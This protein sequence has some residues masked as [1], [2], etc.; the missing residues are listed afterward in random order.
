MGPRVFT[1]REVNALL[2]DLAR[3]FDAL[4]RVPDRLKTAKGKLDVLEMIWGEEVR[5]ETNPDRREHLHWITELEQAKKDHDTAVREI[6]EL[7]G[8]VKSVDQGLVDFYG[9]IE[10]RL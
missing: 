2:P 4:D 1:P 9:V 8:V 7:E 3:C 10:G 5:S 6:A